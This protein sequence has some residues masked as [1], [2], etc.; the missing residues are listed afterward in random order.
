[1][2]QSRLIYPVLLG[3]SVPIGQTD[4]IPPQPRTMSDLATLTANLNELQQQFIQSFRE[5]TSQ[6]ESIKKDEEKKE[7]QQKKE[8]EIIMMLLI[9]LKPD[10]TICILNLLNHINQSVI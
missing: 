2:A 6:I 4:P 9:C 3:H 5:I 8:E 1:M 10:L 7:Q